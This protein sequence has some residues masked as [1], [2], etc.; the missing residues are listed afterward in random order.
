M[1]DR[2]LLKWMKHLPFGQPYD[3]VISLPKASQASTRQALTGGSPSISTQDCGELAFINLGT[4]ALP[5]DGLK[6]IDGLS[7]FQTKNLQKDSEIPWRLLDQYLLE[8]FSHESTLR[9]KG[10]D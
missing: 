3:N 10:R 2:G 9:A 5:I 7:L 4:H 1:A 8:T 6:E